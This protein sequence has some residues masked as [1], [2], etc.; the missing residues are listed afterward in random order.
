MSHPTIVQFIDARLSEE[1]L[2]VAD[3]ADT[4]P[5]KVKR[6]RELAF[7]QSVTYQIRLTLR[8]NRVPATD[9]PMAAGLLIL[10]DV[11]REHPD[12]DLDVWFPTLLR[13][14]SSHGAR[15]G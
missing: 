5:V 10:A 13:G 6:L 8:Q 11:W 1:E 4:D 14:Q 3:R 7:F 15:R 9:H 12:F 2:A